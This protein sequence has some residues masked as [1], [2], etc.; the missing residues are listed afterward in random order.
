[1]QER[2]WKGFSH[3]RMRRSKTFLVSGWRLINF[4]VCA[5]LKLIKKNNDL[6]AGS[7]TE[8]QTL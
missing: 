2:L 6:G 3:H 5:C 8:S 4:S 7:D 1:M